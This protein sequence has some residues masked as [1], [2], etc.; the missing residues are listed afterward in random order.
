MQNGE[1]EKSVGRV[2]AGKGCLCNQ[3]F[4]PTDF[5]L[6]SLV[7][8]IGEA[9]LFSQEKAEKAFFESISRCVNERLRKLHGETL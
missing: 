6:M 5:E 9:A 3:A 7:Q 1:R 2:S 4:E 8:G